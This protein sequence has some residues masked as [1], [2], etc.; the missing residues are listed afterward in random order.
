MYVHKHFFPANLL[1]YFGTSL[2]FTQ[3]DVDD[4]KA[5]SVKHGERGNWLQLDIFKVCDNLL[6]I[7]DRKK[8][9]LPASSGQHRKAGATI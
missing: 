5:E 2:Q 1:Y 7:T 3:N 8:K 4:I 6:A 9:I